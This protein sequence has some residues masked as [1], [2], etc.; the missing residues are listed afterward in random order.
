MLTRRIFL[1]RLAGT[2]GAAMTYEAMTALGL[3]AMPAS[4][5][6]AFE[7]RGQAGGAE[8]LILGAGLAGMTVAY[9]LGKLG[10][11]CTILEAR[12]RP[13]G[14][15]HT[16]R[17]GTSSEEDGSTQ[18]A[19]FDEGMYF[20]P[21]PMRIPHH[22]ASTLG[23]CK[24]LGVPVEVFT[25]ENLNTYFHESG[26]AGT[27][28]RRFRRREVRSDLTGYTAE[29]LSKALS[30]PALNAPM[31]KA[32]LV[33]NI[34]SAAKKNTQPWGLW[35]YKYYNPSGANDGKWV[36]KETLPGP[37]SGSNLFQLG[38]YYSKINDDVIAANP[39]IVRQPN[40]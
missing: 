10:Y 11:K 18:T 39:K 22:H 30:Q 32:D 2:A 9:E 21:G 24:E 23:Y 1:E 3:L 8:V 25:D 38:N 17:K 31:S 37:V 14:R 28:G 33:S 36:F 20:N 40:Q 15:C 13:G 19:S 34:G 6:N 35:P 26:A 16:I 4:S 12:M 5:A 27:P 29:L 7:L